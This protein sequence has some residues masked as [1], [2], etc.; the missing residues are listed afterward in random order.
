VTYVSLVR[1][2][3]TDMDVY[4]HINHAK[5]VTLLEEARIP[6]LF[7]GAVEAGLDMVKFVVPNPF[8]P[9]ESQTFQR[10]VMTAWRAGGTAH[11]SHPLYERDNVPVDLLARAYAAAVEGR[12]GRHV[13]PSFYAG[14]VG[15]FFQHMAQR[16]A[17][18]TGW[19]C[20]L[21]IAPSQSFD[22]PRRRM[23]TQ[24]LDPAIY[25]WSEATFWDEYAR[26]YAA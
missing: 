2:R 10:H 21:T 26:A 12:S 6:L 9:F 4:G 16:I 11:V 1:P 8:G 22:E 5:M 24:P 25:G 14:P 13:S 18:R 19:A 20:G 15:E 23:N 17:A 3:W 7:E